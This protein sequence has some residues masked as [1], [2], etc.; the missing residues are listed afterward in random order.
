MRT[1]K[2]GEKHQFI[3]EIVDADSWDLPCFEKYRQ[4]DMVE[5]DS[6][7]EEWVSWTM[8]TSTFGEALAKAMLEH[9][10]LESKLNPDLDPAAATT[11]ALPDEDKYLYRKV[12]TT[13]RSKYTKLTRVVSQAVSSSSTDPGPGGA[14]QHAQHSPKAPVVASP[15]DIRKAEQKTTVNI[16]KR[17]HNNFISAAMDY[18]IRLAKFETNEYPSKA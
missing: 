5:E 10:T 14:V 13:T 9:K 1:C 12:T 7:Q 16:M 18:K 6:R 11:L 8:A 4:D 2:S 15:Q 3:K 17:A